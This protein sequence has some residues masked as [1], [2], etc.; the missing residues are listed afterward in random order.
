MRGPSGPPDRRCGRQSRVEPGAER[1]LEGE[2]A[3]QAE[4]PVVL[5]AAGPRLVYPR[6]EVPDPVQAAPAD[7]L[8][9]LAVGP[10]RRP[11]EVGAGIRLAE[12]GEQAAAAPQAEA[13]RGAGR[14][15]ARGKGL[16]RRAPK[17]GHPGAEHGAWAAPR[18]RRGRRRTSC[19]STYAQ[20]LAADKQFPVCSGRPGP[21][22]LAMDSSAWSSESAGT[23]P[24]AG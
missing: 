24:A 23:L 16:R 2:R 9:H 7:G 22:R 13:P 18:C 11:L 12:S 17:H 20:A 15:D 21:I 19:R 1:P 4:G 6:H 8:E 14:L 10:A 3:A 5:E